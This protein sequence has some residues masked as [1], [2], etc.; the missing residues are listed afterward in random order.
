MDRYFDFKH[1]KIRDIRLCYKICP[2]IL[3][4][5]SVPTRSSG[6]GRFLWFTNPNRASNCCAFISHAIVNGDPLMLDG[7]NPPLLQLYVDLGFESEYVEAK[8]L[9]EQ[10]ISKSA[11]ACDDMT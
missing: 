9:R 3:I 10:S 4:R 5:L 2:H 6:A 7:G 11:I 8:P 1:S